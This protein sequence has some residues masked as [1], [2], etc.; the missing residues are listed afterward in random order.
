MEDPFADSFNFIN[1]DEGFEPYP[2]E[3]IDS[4]VSADTNLDTC[5]NCGGVEWQSDPIRS[6]AICVACGG[7]VG[8]FTGSLPDGTVLHEGGIIDGEH[9]G[10]NED[11]VEIFPSEVVYIHEIR[12][13]R[14][15][16]KRMAYIRT[17]LRLWLQQQSSIDAE[18]LKLIQHC[19]GKWCEKSG[20]KRLRNL[21]SLQL[22]KGG[23]EPI[24]GYPKLTKDDICSILHACDAVGK[25]LRLTKGSRPRM[26]TLYLEKWL[27]IRFLLTGQK[28][29][30]CLVG[31]EV[32]EFVTAAFEE[33]DKAFPHAVGSVLK[34]Q[35]FPHN[36]SILQRLLVLKGWEHYAVDCA[37]LNSARAKKKF[38]LCWWAFCKYLKWPYISKDAHFLSKRLKNKYNL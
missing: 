4:A 15:A 28:S 19:F 13:S 30:G 37:E 35:A 2:L 38:E 1:F 8:Y 22:H 36:D 6:D 17:K 25:P 5:S 11:S 20:G 33:L 31:Q 24:T 34:R 10:E 16:Y 27:Y 7:C 26:V 32:L 21:T 12:S 9:H 3:P 14:N 29:V 18:D 23:P